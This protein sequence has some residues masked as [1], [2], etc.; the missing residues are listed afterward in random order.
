MVGTSL[1]TLG[2]PG[3]SEGK[4]SAESQVTRAGLSEDPEKG[5]ATHSSILA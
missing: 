2:L 4:E 5:M 3:G 1:T